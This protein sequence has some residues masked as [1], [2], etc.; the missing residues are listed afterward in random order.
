VALNQRAHDSN[1]INIIRTDAD[2]VSLQ[3]A[4]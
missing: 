3:R 2:G 1:N 4:Q